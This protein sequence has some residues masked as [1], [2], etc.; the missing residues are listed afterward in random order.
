MSHFD[1]KVVERHGNRERIA[2]NADDYEELARMAAEKAGV[3]V[4]AADGGETT[5]TDSGT[6]TGGD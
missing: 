3:P 6:A 5:A 4:L 1:L 2:M